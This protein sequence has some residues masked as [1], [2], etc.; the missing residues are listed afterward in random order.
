MAM[1][2]WVDEVPADCG[3]FASAVASVVASEAIVVLV[4]RAGKGGGWGQLSNLVTYFYF[5]LF[6]MNMRTENEGH[7]Q[8]PDKNTCL[9]QIKHFHFFN[10]PNILL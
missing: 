8:S 5:L 2:S 10:I 4:R 3:A 1:R 6:S 9:K 7:K